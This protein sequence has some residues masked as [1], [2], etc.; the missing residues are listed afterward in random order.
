MSLARGPAKEHYFPQTLEVTGRRLDLTY[1][2]QVSG[3]SFLAA[4]VADLKETNMTQPRGTHAL[5]GL[6]L[7]LILATAA[8]GQEG[9]SVDQSKKPI[10]RSSRIYI[11]P[12]EG[13]FDTYLAAAI[14]KK[15]VPV[16]VV[17]DRTKAD[18]EVTG[19]ASTEKAGWAKMLFMGVDNSND[20]ASIKVVELKSSE[21][22]YGYAVRKGNSAR[23]K[24]SAAEACAK[25]LKEKIE[26][27]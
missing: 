7:A 25:H 5:V 24:Q 27:K 20:M 3:P 16:V 4:R 23:G 1:L 11:A 10:E 9:K 13:G 22:V 21:V 6:A 8:A 18:Y 14:I 12:I 15:Q 17:T 2:Y 26:G 19:I